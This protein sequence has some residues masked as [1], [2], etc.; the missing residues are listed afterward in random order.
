MTQCPPGPATALAS[1]IAVFSVSAVAVRVPLLAPVPVQVTAGSAVAATGVDAVFSTLRVVPV[2]SSAKLAMSSALT[3]PWLV[4]VKVIS[5][6]CP[7]GIGLV[8]KDFWIWIGVLTVSAWLKPPLGSPRVLP[9]ALAATTLLKV[10]EVPLMPATIT[11]TVSTQLPL[12]PI[13]PPVSVTDLLSAAALML[14]L[15]AL[16]PVQ[17]TAGVP[18]TSMAWPRPSSGRVSVKLVSGT[19][20]PAFGLLS[21]MVSVTRLPA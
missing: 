11:G 21:V 13:A 16:L 6:A 2:R 4:T 8:A 5:E 1:V 19:S 9:M 15:A 14:P 12:S 18:L 17:L 10:W 7:T 20:A 3:E